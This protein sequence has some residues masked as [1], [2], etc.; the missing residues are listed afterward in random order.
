MITE[1]RGKFRDLIKMEIKTL[2]NLLSPNRYNYQDWLNVGMCL[3]NINEFYL[4]IWDNWSKKDKNKYKPNEC[5]DKWA[6]FSDTLN[7]TLNIGSLLM[8]VKEDNLD[9]F[10]KFIKKKKILDLVNKYKDIFPDNDLD[11]ANII[12]NE[13]SHYI[14]LNDKYCPMAKKEHDTNSL[15]LE[16]SPIEYVMKCHL[17]IGQK[18]PCTHTQ[19]KEK[20]IKQIFNT[21]NIQN[22]N[23]NIY[24]NK[25]DDSQANDE[26]SYEFENVFDDIEFN[27]LIFKSLNQTHYDIAMVLYSIIQ[28]KFIYTFN[29]EWFIFNKNLWKKDNG[30]I[31][32]FLSKEF[33][34]Y[35]DKIN[36]YYIQKRDITKNEIDKKKFNLQIIKISN[37]IK[38]LKTNN[39]KD[40]ILKET[41]NI[42]NAMNKQNNFDFET[43]LDN[44]AYII[45]FNNGIY[46]LNKMVFREGTPD[47]YVSMSVG[48]DY[49]QEP[50][51]NMQ[52]IEQFFKDI[53][54]E[55]SERIYLLT[56][57][58][59]LLEFN[60]PEEKFTIFSG[61]TRNGK[62]KLTDLIS[63]TLGDY[64]GNIQSSMLTK[65]RPSM[66]TP[67]PALINL[68]KKRVVS[69]SEPEE[70]QSINTGFIKGVTGKDKF[71]SRYLY[72]N[73]MITFT[74]KFKLILLCNDKPK[75]NALN[76]QAFWNRCRCIEFPITFVEHPTNEN[77][78][79]ID[80]K[81]DEKMI[82]WK[83]DFFLL[84]L[85]YYQL[86]KSIGLKTT[87][88]VLQY[89][90]KYKN[91]NDY[92][93]EFADKYIIKDDN[94]YIIWTTL[95]ETF[96]D[97]FSEN[98]GNKL[99]QI[100]QIKD[101]FEKNIFLE[102]EKFMTIDKKSYRGWRN[103]ILINNQL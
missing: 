7:N 65:E 9:E 10:T 39:F 102:E 88:K 22:F 12:T 18:Y 24:N 85:R 98:K 37:L 4:D 72:S 93:K 75:V 103:Y 3:H 48:Y 62:T 59:S 71:T 73:D 32:M 80:E 84:L 74:L 49:S 67:Q 13:I 31:N 41:G 26:Y 28:H 69:A 57:L 56:F 76:D 23:I 27:K 33:V 52:S 8:W 42:Y 64:Y 1:K 38:Q 53:Q 89:T 86:Y 60:N 94:S 96:L 30:T 91:E 70:E 44:N 6:T 16:L 47:D 78:K 63:L 19:L 50:S 21:L 77:H 101:Y 99:P 5:R 35:Y 83:N 51:E 29:N 25:S 61:K 68:N 43:T 2:V 45:G 36:M 11:I 82:H 20:E 81:L 54:P 55:E 92:F 15:Y 58:S 46:D 97:W 95:K 79:K 34:E 17:C 87:N 14:G 66:D 100:K 40:N 90:N